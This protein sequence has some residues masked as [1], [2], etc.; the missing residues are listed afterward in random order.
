MKKGAFWAVLT[1]LIVSTLVLVSCSASTSTSTSKSTPTTT[2]AST[3][4][5][6]STPIKSPILVSTTTLS[7]TTAGNWWDT[8]GKPQYGGQINFRIDRDI[9]N[10]DPYNQELLTQIETGWLEPIFVPD[11][12]LDPAIN[13]Y[14]LNFSSDE[15]EKGE[16]AQSWEFAQPNSLVVH[17]R[18][19]IQWQNIPPV[20]G[21]EFIADDVVYHFDRLFG[22][23]GG[24]TKPSSYWGS[25]AVWQSLKS[26]TAID[27]YTVVF[28]W[29]TSNPE[30]I[31]GTMEALSSD[32]WIEAPEAV[33]LWGDLNDWRHAIGTG[34]FILTDF[35]SGSSATLVKNPNYWGYDERY[36]QN[37]LPYVDALKILI[38]PD[39][40]TAMSA[41]RT[42]KIDMMD[43]VS[44]Q[45]AQSMQKTNP[46]ILQINIPATLNTITLDPRLDKAPFN[47]I[48]VRKAMQMAIDLPTI[49]KNYYGGTADP[50]PSTETSN[51]MKGWGSPF[52][53][54]PQDL[55]DEY[56]YN[57]T[58]AKQLLAAAGFPS[59]FKTNVVADS[60]GDMDLLQIIKSY[61]ANIGIDMS[62]TTMDTQSWTSFVMT[63]HKQDA[64]AYRSIGSL[65]FAYEPIRQ[66]TKF[67]TGAPTSP[68][69]IS[70]P[71]YDAFYPKAMSATSMDVVKQ[72]VTDMDVY[73]A[74][75]HFVMSLLQ[76]YGFS[77]YQPWFNSY[78]GQLGIALATG[79]GPLVLDFYGARFWIDQKM[80]IGH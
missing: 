16:L 34:P 78:N 44:R 75:Q 58:V 54:W 31:L 43:N 60:A 57:P 23:G 67:V 51:Y 2:S 47:D 77:L 11:W 3:P 71:V 62:V 30:F 79:R 22:L 18:H 39:A 64:L 41:M 70:D 9:V 63:N 5:Q 59:G 17:L 36:P 69:N 68:G 55:K 25:V 38:I 48:R 45:N 19:G 28:N 29:N 24:F 65:G 7:S 76:P 50:W 56:A 61:F 49:A 14:K 80:K 73:V 72:V 40:N 53:Q 74:R 27:K 26:V 8:I 1:C 21:R 42:G 20:N 46:E 4:I 33:K 10:F 52:I 12:T 66:L 13:D 32:Q 15:Y 37:K 35:V 6:A